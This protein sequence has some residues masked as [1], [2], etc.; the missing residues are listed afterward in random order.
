MY[1][2]RICGAAAGAV[3]KRLAGNDG[4][5]ADLVDNLRPLLERAAPPLIARGQLWLDTLYLNDQPAACTLQFPHPTGPQLY[6]CGFDA[7]KREYSPGVVL[8]AE[9]LRHAIES[10]ANTFDLLRG[11]EPYKYKLGARD[12]PLWMIT[13]TRV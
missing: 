4:E 13:L 6:N 9:I 2:R 11:Q 7:A 5:V 8:T 12:I 3:D 10:G 1:F